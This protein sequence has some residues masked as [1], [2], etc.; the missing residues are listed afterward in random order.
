MLWDHCSTQSFRTVMWYHG[1]RS[2][3]R[4]QPVSST[5][6]SKQQR[7]LVILSTVSLSTA[8]WTHAGSRMM[9]IYKANYVIRLRHAMSNIA[10]ASHCRRGSCSEVCGWQPNCRVDIFT[11]QWHQSC[12]LIS[13]VPDLIPGM[14]AT[15]PFQTICL[16]I[17]RIKGAQNKMCWT[18]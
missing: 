9:A 5:D 2:P 14:L 18:D 16:L 15:I 17:C 1:T 4:Q 7:W 8:R 12:R 11:T 6:I 3:G 10:D 13:D